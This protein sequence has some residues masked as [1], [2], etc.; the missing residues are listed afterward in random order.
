VAV[1]T[2]AFRIPRQRVEIVAAA[3][4]D[5][6]GLVGAVPLLELRRPPLNPP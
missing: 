1:A 3:L 5:D 2:T 4:G 6:V